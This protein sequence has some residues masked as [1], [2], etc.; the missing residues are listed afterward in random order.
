MQGGG[1]KGVRGG[2]VRG[3]GG[4]HKMIIGRDNAFDK[5]HAVLSPDFFIAVQ[6]PV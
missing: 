1:E 4:S 5:G 6:T 3:R 2:C